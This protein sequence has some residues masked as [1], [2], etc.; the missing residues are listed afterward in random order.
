[1]DTLISPRR[2]MVLGVLGAASLLGACGERPRAKAAIEF[3]GATMGSLNRVKIAD[4][5]VPRVFE[6]AETDNF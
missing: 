3:G 2:R 4:A 1:M 6:V 5:N